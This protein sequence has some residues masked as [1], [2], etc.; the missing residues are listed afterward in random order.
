MDFYPIFIS[1]SLKGFPTAAQN[2]QTLEGIFSIHSS[3]YPCA[4]AFSK[5]LSHPKSLFGFFKSEKKD[6]LTLNEPSFHSTYESDSFS[7][8]ITDSTNDE[9]KDSLLFVLIP[10]QAHQVGE[11]KFYVQSTVLLGPH[12]LMHI[13]SILFPYFC[14]S[15]LLRK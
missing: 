1:A 15:I 10:W 5:P 9:P 13:A 14:R 2:A 4:L 3:L 11:Q 7:L 6:S 12:L 8:H